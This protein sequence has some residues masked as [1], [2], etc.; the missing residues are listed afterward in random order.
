MFM[1]R[2]LAIHGYLG[3]DKGGGGGGGQDVS[4]LEETFDE[5]V[6]DEEDTSDKDGSTFVS[7][8]ADP[9]EPESGLP[10]KPKPKEK[11]PVEKAKEPKEPKKEEQPKEPEEAK[12]LA[13]ADEIANKAKEEAAPKKGGVIP[14]DRHET[15]LNKMR[16]ERDEAVRALANAQGGQK[17]AQVNTEISTLESEVDTLQDQYD[18]ALIDGEKETAR[19]LARQL[20]T[21]ERMLGDKKTEIAVSIA[22]A[23][24]IESTRFDIA[25]ER[26]EA[27]YPILQPGHD[28]YD[29]KMMDAVLE[30]TRM[31]QQYGYTATD[32]MQRAVRLKLGAE[33]VTQQ[34]AAQVKPRVNDEDLKD[35]R[36]ENAVDKALKTQQPPSTA[37]VGLDSDKLG[38]KHTAKD[39]M[40]MSDKEF[41]ALSDEELAKLGGD[42]RLV[43][44]DQD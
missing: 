40:K 30:L 11:S 44:E 12:T 14:V 25:R 38:R 22:R 43:E 31:H 19:G 20:R 17:I 5:K 23:E 39:V 7:D 13:D 4:H 41:D 1:Q 34:E 16:D 35:K 36:K 26:I 24:A 2:F 32:S 3:P 33:T 28:D 42:F 8:E 21:K 18:T 15:I 29:Q 27:A 10:D 6:L 9:D 37:K